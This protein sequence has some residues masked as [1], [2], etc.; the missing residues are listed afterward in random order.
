[1]VLEV[2]VEELHILSQQLPLVTVEAILHFT[3]LHQQAVVAVVE[4]SLMDH[5]LE[6][7]V[8]VQEETL[9]PL[10]LLELLDRETL[11]LQR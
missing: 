9:V 6:V 5:F 8:V 11:D 7:L 2:L 10:V 1:L 3:R 4:K